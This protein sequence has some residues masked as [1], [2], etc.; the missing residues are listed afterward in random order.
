MM[1]LNRITLVGYTGGDA[2]SSSNGPT[3]LTL[4]TNT[5][6]VDKQTNER[7]TRTEWHQLVIWNGLGRWAASLQK[8]TPLL[9][10]GELIYEQYERKTE[11]ALGK[12]TVEVE[13]PTRVAKI[14]V[15]NIIRLA[16]A[17]D[18]AEEPT[19]A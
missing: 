11:T 6:W 13:I 8:G 14:R 9:V 10:E 19:A 3:A 7:R 15:Q 5:T 12:K 18:S 1:N 17:D 2:K 16:A 4:A